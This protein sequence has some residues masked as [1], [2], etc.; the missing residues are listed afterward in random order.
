MKYFS[1]GILF[2]FLTFTSASAAG[3]GSIHKYVN[4]LASARARRFLRAH[5]LQGDV[6]QAAKDLIQ[7]AILQRRERGLLEQT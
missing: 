2:S 5:I 6:L 7:M 4:R 1:V 3:W